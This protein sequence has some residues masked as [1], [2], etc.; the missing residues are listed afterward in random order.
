M[1][2]S[3]IYIVQVEEEEAS[4]VQLNQSNF[5]ISAGVLLI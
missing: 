2:I 1:C 4:T 3:F 5:G